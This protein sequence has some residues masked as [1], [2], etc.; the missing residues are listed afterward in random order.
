MEHS[1]KRFMIRKEDIKFAES[2][3]NLM[4]NQ[5]IRL[6]TLAR[7]LSVNKSTLHNWQNGVL[8]SNLVALVKL[9]L[10]FDLSL[11]EL[12][13][14]KAKQLEKQGPLKFTLT[15]EASEKEQLIK[16]LLE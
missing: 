16:H 15:L 7:K 6:S 12:C 10:Y 9:A 11:D 14:G 8:P 2:L 5:N 4:S 13:L 1:K 3:N